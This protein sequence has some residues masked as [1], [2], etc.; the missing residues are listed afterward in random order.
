MG[1]RIPI[2][3]GLFPSQFHGWN[4]NPRRNIA[5]PFHSIQR[6]EHPL[7]IPC[8]SSWSSPSICWSFFLFFFS[9]VAHRDYQIPAQTPSKKEVRSSNLQDNL[10]CHFLLAFKARCLTDKQSNFDKKETQLNPLFFFD[11]HVFFLTLSMAVVVGISCR[12][13]NV[14]FNFFF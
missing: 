9:K 5:P 12:D 13:M 2:V 7:L 6:P 4:S 10:V 11:F 8:W 3:F 1:R 14:C